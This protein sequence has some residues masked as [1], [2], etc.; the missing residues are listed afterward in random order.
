MS[1]AEDYAKI[2]VSTACAFVGLAAGGYLFKK[3]FPNDPTD[4]QLIAVESMARA[5][6]QE[7][8]DSQAAD[9]VRADVSLSKAQI[10]NKI[11]LIKRNYVMGNIEPLLTRLSLVHDT[12]EQGRAFRV[13][14]GMVVNNLCGMHV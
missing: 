7:W 14:A 9:P 6:I 13:K 12:L 11:A 1:F 8:V 3:L 5:L 2:L 4:N 10:D